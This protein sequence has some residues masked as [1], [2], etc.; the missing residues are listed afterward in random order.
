MKKLVVSLAVVALAFSF[1][2]CKKCGQCVCDG[3]ASSEVCKKDVGNT[4]YDLTKSSCQTNL[5]GT[6]CTW[7]E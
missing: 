4:L 1:T 2:S 6:T 5:G 3:V 7:E